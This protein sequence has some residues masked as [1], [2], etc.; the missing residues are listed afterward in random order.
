M[1]L[2]MIG[3]DLGKTIYH[4][5]GLDLRGRVVVRKRFSRSQLLHFTSNLRV[6][7]IGIEACGGAHFL[8]RAPQ[9]VRQVRLMSAQ[10]V[11]LFVK[12][13]KNDYIDA[14]SISEAAARPTMC[15][16]SIKT[17]DSLVCRWQ[18]NLNLKL[19]LCD[20]G[21]SPSSRDD[22]SQQHRL[23]RLLNG[24]GQHLIGEIA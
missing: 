9:H 1:E 16:V 19:S 10:Y 17:D 11:K 5:A 21:N 8:G 6:E 15:F 23:P 22:S 18:R 13:N 12:T 4:L 14:E 24:M 7:M 3:I 2:H 20:G